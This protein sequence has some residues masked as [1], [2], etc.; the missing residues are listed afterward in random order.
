MTAKEC[1]EADILRRSGRLE[2]AE[3][4]LAAAPLTPENLGALAEVQFER[5]AFA[6]CDKTLSRLLR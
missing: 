3:A 6:R 4:L 1:A 5:R 2:E